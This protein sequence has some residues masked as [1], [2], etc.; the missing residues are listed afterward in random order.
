MFKAILTVVA[1]FYLDVSKCSARF[2]KE[3]VRLRVLCHV[4]MSESQ[5]TVI[6]AM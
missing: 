2:T 5:T 1:S 4:L 3:V 6:I